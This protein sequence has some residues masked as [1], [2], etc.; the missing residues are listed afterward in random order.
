MA[1]F[2]HAALAQQTPPE[3]PQASP[4]ASVMQ[5]VGLTKFT[6]T[7]SS[8]GVKGRT[9]WGE[10]VPYDQLWRTGAN[11]ATQIEA[12]R[13]FTFGGTKVPAGTYALYTIPGKSSWTVILNKNPN[14]G[15]TRGYDEKNDVARISVTPTQIPARE[16]LAF[17]FSNTTEDSSRLDL[18]WDTLRVS[19][20][21]K[22]DTAQQ[23][24]A[25]IDKALA[26]AWRPHF[27]SA[28]YLLDSG[29]DLKTALG[30]IDTSIAIKSTW[31]NNWV[32]A[33]ILAKQGNQAEAVVA[34]EQAQKLG[35]GDEIYEGFFKDQIAKSIAD[36]KKPS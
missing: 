14:A 5:Q 34:A 26:D 27:A 29:G 7:Y 2:A 4:N 33:Q 31:W 19:M 12:S 3:L 24:T 6:V 35:Q 28:R 25:N 8:P 15:G 32:K 18:E 23:A 16:R 10:L 22:V 11:L 17:L 36:W 1:A 9:V 13:D 21:I 30:Y 20:P